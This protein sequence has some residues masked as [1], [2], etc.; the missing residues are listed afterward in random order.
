VTKVRYGSDTN[1]SILSNNDYDQART[2]LNLALYFG[3]RED[4]LTEVQKSSAQSLRAQKVI[5]S[6]SLL[7][8]LTCFLAL[9]FKSSIIAS[10]AFIFQYLSK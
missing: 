5:A 3:G 6:R 10:E 8:F 1:E 4:G 7:R 9:L 2:V